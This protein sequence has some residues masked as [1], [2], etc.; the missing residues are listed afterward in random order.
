MFA[1]K[2]S[3]SDDN[4]M[5]FALERLGDSI[6]GDLQQPYTDS[7]VHNVPLVSKKR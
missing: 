2:Y 1:L 4:D 3:V 6:L 7:R 5:M